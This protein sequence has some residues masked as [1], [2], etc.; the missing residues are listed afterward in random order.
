MA[1]AIMHFVPMLIALAR[2]KG[3]ALYIGEGR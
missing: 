1:T 2:E 3:V